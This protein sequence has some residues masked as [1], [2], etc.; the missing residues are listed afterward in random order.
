MPVIFPRSFMPPP[1]GV[2]FAPPTQGGPSEPIDFTT[3][4]QKRISQ[5]CVADQSKSTKKRRVTRKKP[6]SIELDDVK[7]KVEVLKNNGHWKDHW[8]I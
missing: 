7:D 8:V 4:S 5:E 1:P 3:G 6:E 2:G